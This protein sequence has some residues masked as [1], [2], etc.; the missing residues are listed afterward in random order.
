LTIGED[1]VNEVFNKLKGLLEK[2][3]PNTQIHISLDFET[4]SE[5]DTALDVQIVY[6]EDYR[7]GNLVLIPYKYPTY[8]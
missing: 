4:L 2:E 1:N 6:Y 8:R 5:L 3:F 7:L